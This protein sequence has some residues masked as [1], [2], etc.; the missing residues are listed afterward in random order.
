MPLAIIVCGG[1][2]FSDQQFVYDFLSGIDY[3]RG[4]VALLIEGGATGADRHASNW[5]IAN[6]KKHCRVR[7]DWDLGR[8][9]G[10][11]RNQEMLDLLIAW[12]DSSI[13][14]LVIAFPSAT[15]ASGRGGTLDMI[16]RAQSAGIETIIPVYNKKALAP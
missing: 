14:K 12:G 5:A 9:A 16:T 15:M 11:R 13:Q 8:S 10:P 2:S 1:R 3:D 4:G 6:K 7:A